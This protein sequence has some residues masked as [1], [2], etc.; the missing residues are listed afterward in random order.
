MEL[1]SYEKRGY[2]HEDFRLF[3]LTTAMEQEVDWHYHAFHKIIV[4][5]GG[6]AV[7]YGIEGK[8]YPLQPGDIIL[9]PQGCIHRPEIKRG[10][11]YDRMI[12]YISPEF[13]CRSSEDDSLEACFAHAA[14]EFHFVVRA[15]GQNRALLQP[16]YAMEQA[17]RQSAFASTLLTRSLFFQF[18]IFLTRE[19]AR[20][21]LVYAPAAQCDEK[22]VAIMQYLS[23]HPTDQISIDD[24]A[25]QFYIS[26]YYMMRR[27]RAQTGY[28]IHAYLIGKRL[29]L[30]REKIAGG[31]PAGEAAYACGFG[32]YSAFSRAYR[33]QF[34]QTPRA[35]KTEE[36]LH[37]DGK[38]A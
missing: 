6:A 1:Q 18:L 32:D 26:K 27:F 2:L 37:K 16:L 29:M 33:K 15:G 38:E 31:M 5:L 4:Y 14:R 23:Q 19:T 35:A 20:G 11:A 24:L 10:T 28:T 25:T 34:G 7:F 36:F 22:I 9:V 17:E 12:L 8:S 21:E 30:A 3:H 13:L